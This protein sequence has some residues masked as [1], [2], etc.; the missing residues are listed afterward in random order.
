M[1]GQRRVRRALTAIGV[2]SATLLVGGETAGAGTLHYGPG[3]EGEAGQIWY[4]GGNP[5]NLVANRIEARWTPQD[6]GTLVFTDTTPI[7]PNAPYSDPL[8]CLPL[9]LTARCAPVGRAAFYVFG[10]RGYFAL[11][12]K[13]PVSVNGWDGDDTISGGGAADTLVG[14]GGDDLL[15]GN[16]GDDSLW[17]GGAINQNDQ[18]AFV[19]GTGNDEIH[20]R[21]FGLADTVDCG[22]GRDTVFADGRDL[23]AANC[24][25]VFVGD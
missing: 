18:D 4:D 22:P 25:Q 20:S 19:G 15:L 14:G 1:G 3:A 5:P 10:E 8:G 7:V 2:V 17:A 9:V 12:G 11:R 16:G 21:D 24:E 6:G 13:L 23:V